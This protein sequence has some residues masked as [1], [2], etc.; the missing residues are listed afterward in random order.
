MGGTRLGSL[1]RARAR[2]GEHVTKVQARQ[3]TKS[4]PRRKPSANDAGEHCAQTDGR[5]AR[6]LRTEA[7]L[8]AAFEAILRK[9]GVAALGVNA[10]AERARVEKVLIYRYFGG[11]EGLMAEYAKRSE[12]WPTLDEIIGPDP[13]L[14]RDPDRPR[15]AARLL[16]NYAR[17]LR[18]RPVT[19][20]LLA[21]ECAQRNALTVALESVR[22]E[23][24]LQLFQ[25]LTAAGFAVHGEAAELSALLS[26]AINYLAV[27]GREIKVFGGLRVGDDAAWEHIE[28]LMAL[29][30]RGVFERR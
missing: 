29:A 2:R 30:L 13:M 3:R 24:A 20:D 7:R 11:L 26:G 14:L 1:G 28:A 15:A 5:H 25:H 9:Q 21:W 10:I 22:E 12:F 6:R 8:F 19:L 4:K 23:R 27:R 17:A 16:G 18:K